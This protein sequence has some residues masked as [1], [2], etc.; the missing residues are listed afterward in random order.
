MGQP[1]QSLLCELC[2]TDP[3]SLDFAIPVGKWYMLGLSMYLVMCYPEPPF[4]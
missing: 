1:L 3:V 4:G 2:N